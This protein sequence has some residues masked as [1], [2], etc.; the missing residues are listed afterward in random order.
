LKIAYAFRRG[1]FYPFIAGA[2]WSLPDGKTRTSYLKKVRDIGFDG[3]ELGLESFGGQDAVKN[4]V[5]ELQKVLEDAGAPCVVIRAGG[6]LCQPNVAQRNRQRLEKAVE[7][8]SWIGADTV[9][10]ALGT[11]PRNRNLDT[12]PVGASEAHGSS[13]M[14]AEEDYTRTAK[15]LREVGQV[16]G[17][18]G[19]NITIEVHQHSIADNSWSTL[20]LLDMAGSPYVF[21]N[22]DLGNVYWNYDVPEESSEDCIVALASR[23][24]YW[25]C[26]NLN[27]VYIPEIEHSYYVRVPL[28]DGDIDYRFAISAMVEAG[29]DSYLAIEG[30]QLGDQLHKDER[31][32]DYVRS[33]LTE[34]GA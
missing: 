24:K 15:V 29:F 7:I 23:S 12:G 11:P 26:K 19:V 27:R 32:V 30:A 25:H 28:P 20:H 16:A 33:I 1:T 5:M 34:L 4:K 22:P 14:A 9:N 31:S 6:G 17:N 10:T 2:A 21:A 8:A 18:S 3:I 13:Q